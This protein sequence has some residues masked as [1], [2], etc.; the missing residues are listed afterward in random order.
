MIVFQTSFEAYL[1][2]I[3]ANLYHCFC[4]LAQFRNSTFII[5]WKNGNV[6]RASSGYYQYHVENRRNVSNELWSLWSDVVDYHVPDYG[7]IKNMTFQHQAKLEYN[8]ENIM[9]LHMKY[10]SFYLLIL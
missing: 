5:S 1:P 9:H 4:Q 7:S 8:Y 6:S 10:V 3:L 2:N